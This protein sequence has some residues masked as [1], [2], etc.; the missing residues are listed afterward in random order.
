MARH[1]DKA[2]VLHR[3]ALRAKYG[4]DGLAAIRDALARMAEADRAREISS[5]I[6]AVDRAGTM[7]GLGGPTVADPTDAM[8]VKAAIDAAADAVTAHYVMLVG[9]PDVLAPATPAQPHQRRGPGRP[10][11]PP[12]CLPRAGQRR[13]RRLRR[14]GAGGW[15]PA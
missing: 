12:L 15:S 6:I 7:K 1:V 8:A 2:I 9:A 10:E 13:P 5:R 4:A 14:T 11:R 3:G